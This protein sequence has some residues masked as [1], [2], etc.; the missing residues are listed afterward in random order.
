MSIENSIWS[1][2]C[3]HGELLKRGFEVAQSKVAKSMVKRKRPLSQGWRT[4]L[5]NYA[6]DMAAMD[7]FVVSTIRFNL[8]YALVIA[9]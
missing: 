1:A 5:W 7:M 6:P 3:I 9:G 4:S 8:F 2:P